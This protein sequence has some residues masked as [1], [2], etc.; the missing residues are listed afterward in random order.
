[1]TI[2]LLCDTI[3]SMQSLSKTISKLIFLLVNLLVAMTPFLF[4]GVNEELF[5]FN[6]MLF[7]Y[8]VVLLMVSLWILKMILEKKILF[9][10]SFFDLPLLL[11]FLGQLLSTVFSIHQRTSLFGY[12]GRFHGGLL[13]TLAYCLFYWATVSNLGKK[14]LKVVM[15]TAILSAVMVSLY[16]IPERMG[17]SPSCIILRQEF[18]VSCWI[19]DVQSRVFATFGQPN[20]LAA[21]LS[22]I[23]PITTIFFLFPSKSFSLFPPV[24]TQKVFWLI[25]ITAMTIALLF[26]KSRSGLIALIISVVV[27]LAYVIYQVINNSVSKKKVQ[28]NSFLIILSVIVTVMLIFGTEL[29]PPLTQLLSRMNNSD[30]SNTHIE[31]N[32]KEPIEI[33]DQGILITPSENIRKV[34]WKGATEIWQRYPWLGSGPETFAYSYYLDRPEEHNHLSEWDFLYNK[35]HNEHLN[36]LANSG[37]IG[38]GTYLLVVGSSLY[39]AVKIVRKKNLNPE[40]KWSALTI[41]SSLL[42]IQVTNFFGFS[43]VMIGVISSLFLAYLALI[44]HK[45][46]IA[47]QPQVKNVSFFQRA[48]IFCLAIL[49]IHGILSIISLWQA[50]YFFVKGKVLI[51]SAEYQEGVNYLQRAIVLSPHEALFYDE[52]ANT[53]AQVAVEFLQLDDIQSAKEFAQL[54]I[55]TNDKTIKLNP[56]HLNFL[57][58]RISIF[59]RLALIDIAYLDQALQTIKL[60]KTLAPTHPKLLFNQGRIELSMG[61]EIKAIKSIQTAIT[62]KPNYH[63]ARYR[64]GQIYEQDPKD[65][66]LA[67]E[68]YQYIIEKIIPNDQHLLQKLKELDC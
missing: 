57:Q 21:Y 25:G 46:T 18:N 39:L 2:S 48:T 68:Q 38:L 29:T 54:A 55:A 15:M 6:K 35:A 51:Q 37:I 28:Y 62:M 14:Q 27:I 58:T 42:A 20:W 9:I 7:V 10:R 41:G 61:N 40:T 1:M 64:L 60:A 30:D 59:T 50:D 52:L 19:Q 17:I 36:F 16:A 3:L 33:S 67:K 5:E 53:Y 63:E 8:F 31:K 66:S 23:L 26:T 12:Y 43:T 44:S 32:A 22:A 4:T 56:K 49:V 13:S 45:E 47:N 24:K 11:F 65:C 34:V